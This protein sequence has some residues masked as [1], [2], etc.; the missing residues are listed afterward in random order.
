MMKKRTIW[1]MSLIVILT[2]GVSFVNAEPQSLDVSGKSINITVSDGGTLNL[3]GDSEKALGAY[4]SSPSGFTDVNV[5]NDLVVDGITTV[6]D[7]LYFDGATTIGI[8]WSG[9]D[10]EK[11]IG[12]GWI[13]LGGATPGDEGWLANAA[14]TAIY[15]STNVSGEYYRVL[16]AGNATT[17]PATNDTYLYVA[18]SKEALF[19]GAVNASSTIGVTGAAKLY[20]TLAVTGATTL[21]STLAVT[22]GATL[23]STLAVTGAVTMASTLEL[24]GTASTTGS[25]VLKSATISSDTGAISF[26]NENLTTTGTLASGALTV[27]G[28]ATVSTT[29]GVTGATTLSSTLGVTG[30]TTLSDVLSVAGATT[31]SSNLTVDTDTLWVGASAN[32]VGVGSTTP[33]ATLSVDTDA[34]SR[35]FLVG[36]ST[37]NLFLIDQN[38]D[39]VVNDN[40][41]Y[42]DFSSGYT[43]FGTTT[44]FAALSVTNTGT[45]L[46]LAY[47]TANY[48]TLNTGSTGYFN[49]V[50]SG[51][52]VGIASTTPFGTLAINTSAGVNPFVIGSSTETW[53]KVDSSGLL[54]VA[55]GTTLS[56]TLA[57]T[58]T[59]TL[60]SDLIVDTNSLVVDAAN[61]KVG[62]ASTTP[63]G[64]LSIGTGGI[65]A[66]STISAGKF[67]M[68]ASQENGVS[69]YVR[70][71]STGANGSP[72]A[73]STTSCF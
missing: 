34:G 47:D 44:P 36:S 33:F 69:V 41:L 13:S 38:M 16:I 48:T 43:G 19:S 53:L 11:N 65:V 56:S 67:C 14:N 21:S 25:A 4:I 24:A 55:K 60:S 28:A 37:R 26:S 64:Q 39:L 5:T 52:R 46:D 58:A 40:D 45:Q 27:T 23:S 22:S 54:T 35:A 62:V 49:I 8:R 73:T 12:G 66:T 32:R 1:L 29:L 42:V 50:P 71:T 51:L 7:Y 68:L 6:N 17:T 30:A 63:F 72:F 3:L 20:S 70:L 18:N 15:P 59:T 10:L 61:N 9:S 57:V 2:V 31:L